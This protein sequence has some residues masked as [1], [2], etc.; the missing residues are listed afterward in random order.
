MTPIRLEFANVGTLATYTPESGTIA[1]G[2]AA[3]LWP[4]TAGQVEV[5]DQV[6][7]SVAT[8][9]PSIQADVQCNDIGS[10]FTVRF[11]RVDDGNYWQADLSFEESQLRLTEVLN[12][13]PR[14]EQSFPIGVA[15][16]TNK[17]YSLA[18][19]VS[20]DA[21][22]C[23]VDEAEVMNVAVPGRSSVN[24]NGIAME[25]TPGMVT[26]NRLIIQGT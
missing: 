7:A 20:G 8:C 16:E 25:G 19:A 24:A 14:Y 11:N 26:M 13:T 2:G 9:N 23:K 18:L 4:V 6:T 3:S 10:S 22:T 1:W 5:G 15:L 17:L 12:N 21:V